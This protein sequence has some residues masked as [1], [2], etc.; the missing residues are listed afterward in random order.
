MAERRAARRAPGAPRPDAA[1]RGLDG[2][3]EEVALLRSVI[4]E[5]GARGEVQEARRQ[6]DTLCRVLRTRYLLDDRAV[7][8]LSA[9]L[10]RVLEEAGGA[11]EG[12]G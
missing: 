9:A 2:L 3:D 11:L 4:R 8:A 7:D 1:P 10:V 6:I 12:E 5:L